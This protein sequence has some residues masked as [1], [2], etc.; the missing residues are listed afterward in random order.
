MNLHFAIAS[1][2]INS[3]LR[4]SNRICN[5]SYCNGILTKKHLAYKQ[6]L[7]FLLQLVSLAKWLG[8]F[9]RTKWLWAWAP[10]HSHKSWYIRSCM[11]IILFDLWRKF[12]I[13][14]YH[15]QNCAINHVQYSH[16]ATLLNNTLQLST[17][18]NMKYAD[19]NTYRFRGVG[20]IWT[21][22]FKIS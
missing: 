11:C 4:A 13:C 20:R 5:L 21:K 18:E 19:F 14:W 12:L 8:V 15:P 2:S 1:R 3:L 7:N 17:A 6:T 9:L 22:Y 10:L 16:H